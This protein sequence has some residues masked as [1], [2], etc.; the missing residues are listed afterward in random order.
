MQ[1][2]KK[3][4]AQRILSALSENQGVP[5]CGKMRARL[6]LP[7]TVHCDAQC[8]VWRRRFYPFGVSSEKQR[9]GK[10]N[11]MHGNPV[12]CGL[13]ASPQQWPWSSFRFYY[14]NDSSVLSMDRL[15]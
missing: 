1:E 13:V 11:Y 12:K 15:A 9:L 10:L 5:W 4:T 6:R 7:P 3:R 8:R 14:L 2:L